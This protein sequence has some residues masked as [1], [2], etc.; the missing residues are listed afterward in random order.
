MSKKTAIIIIT[1][2]ILLVAGGLLFFYFYANRGQ[3]ND[4]IPTQ[5]G[6]DLFPNTSGNQTSNPT[7]ATTPTTGTTQGQGTSQNLSTLK[8]LSTRPSAGA[9]VIA[10]SSG[11]FARFIEKGTGNVYQVSPENSDEV[12]L[13]NTTIPK[14]QEVVWQGDALHLIARYTKDG[15]NDTIQSYYAKLTSPTAVEPDGALQGAFLSDN[16]SFI[17]KNPDQNKIFYIIPNSGGSTG[18]L[19]NFDGTGKIQIFASPLKEW[20]TQWVSANTIALLT[21]PSAGIQGF[22]FFLNAKTGALT[23]AITGVNGLTALVSPDSSTALY[24]TSYQ[25]TLSLNLYSFSAGTTESVAIATLP[26][27]CVWSKNDTATIYCGVP[28]YIPNGA[29]PD[30]W[31]QGLT[32]FS[33][34]IWKIDATTGT[35]RIIAHLK[36]LSGKDIDTT[37]L[38]MDEKENYLFF[39]NKKDFHVWSLKLNN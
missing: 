23:R 39:T 35:A 25:G 1:A 19:S 10:T 26:E 34:D 30:D 15:E 37:N 22:L 20:Q 32:S 31:Y 28:N 24:S 14:I 7:G 17:A 18:I 36:N 11:I 5:T 6:T 27:K 3:G 13:S 12:R 16:I 4:I 29:Y 21:K 9:M 38:F 2:I 8:E 33:D